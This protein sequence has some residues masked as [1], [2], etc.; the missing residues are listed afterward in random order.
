[1]RAMLRTR[2]PSIAAAPPESPE[3]APRV[4]T[5]MPCLPVVT[6]GQQRHH[7]WTR[8]AARP[9]GD[10]ARPDAP[11]HVGTRPSSAGPKP[12]CSRQ[13]VQQV[14]LLRSFPIPNRDTALTRIGVVLESRSIR[15]FADFLKPER[16]AVTVNPSQY[17]SRVTLLMSARSG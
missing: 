13:D 3:P 16:H 8:P 10:R 17:V 15:P 5:G 2:Q 1:M 9:T 12:I 11:D 4:T 6:Q 14:R 7:S